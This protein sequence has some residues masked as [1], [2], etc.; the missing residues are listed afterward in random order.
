[1]YAMLRCPVRHKE[2]GLEA[3]EDRVQA[4]ELAA[5]FKMRLQFV[6]LIP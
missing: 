4:M 2:K 1:M 5:F 3:V 6:E